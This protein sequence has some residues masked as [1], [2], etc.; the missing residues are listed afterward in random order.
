MIMVILNQLIYTFLLSFACRPIDKQWDSTIPGT[1]I[2]QLATYFG[3]LVL[4]VMW[5]TVLTVLQDWEVS[6]R[7]TRSV[8]DVH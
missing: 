4:A 2:D 7:R 6:S 3:K 1:C 5:N 8:T